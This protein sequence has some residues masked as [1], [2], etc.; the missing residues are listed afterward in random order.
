MIKATKSTDLLIKSMT[1]RTFFIK[2]RPNER[3]LF[4]TLISPLCKYSPSIH[5]YWKEMHSHR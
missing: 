4:I 5:V 2:N 3:K 1:E